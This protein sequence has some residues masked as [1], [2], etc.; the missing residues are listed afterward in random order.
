MTAFFFLGSRTMVRPVWAAGLA[1]TIAVRRNIVLFAVALFT[2]REVSPT[3]KIT[4]SFCS[5]YYY[6]LVEYVK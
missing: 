6:L 5:K 4:L 2:L 3:Q 1:R